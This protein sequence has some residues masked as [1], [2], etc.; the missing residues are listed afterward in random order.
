MGISTPTRRDQDHVLV[1]GEALV[2]VRVEAEAEAEAGAGER[3]GEQPAVHATTQHA[4]VDREH[5]GGSPLN[6]AVGLARLGV[7]TTL[8]AQVGTDARGEQVA[9]HVEASGAQLARLRPQ[10]PTS[11]ATARVQPGGTA[12]Y[13]FDVTWDPS[14]LP[15]PAGYAAVHVGSLGATLAPG[16]DAVALLVARAV[17]ARVPVCFDPNVRPAVTPDLD[18]VRRRA[19]ALA[20]VATVVKLS[21]EDADLLYPG[22]PVERL[23]ADLATVPGVR[24]AV[25]TLGGGGLLL[26]AGAD[27]VQVATPPVDVVDTIGAGDT[28]MAALI[29]GLLVTGLR[30]AGP[31][32][33]GLPRTGLPRAG[34]PASLVG[35]ETLR[36]LGRLAAGAAAI[37]CS[38][39]GADPPWRPEVATLFTG[40]PTDLSAK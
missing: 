37:T 40:V 11:T 25:V 17:A 27:R 9:R 7:P 15:D 18:D 3:A 14:Y 32:R 1:V 19:H 36:W 21:D 8:A 20:A 26:A 16:A 35:P 24:L 12:R 2:D 4:E 30:E 38:R 10:H 31:P 5:P 29:A 23:A 34:D 6:I 28:V 33:A 13:D 39:P 22:V